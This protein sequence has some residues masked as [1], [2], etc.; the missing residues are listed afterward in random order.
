[1]LDRRGLRLHLATTLGRL[2]EPILFLHQGSPPHTDVNFCGLE[3]WRGLR[4]VAGPVDLFALRLDQS[5]TTSL[6]IAWSRPDSQQ[7]CVLTL[8][9]G[10]LEKS[11]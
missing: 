11:V 6:D 4:L 1:M 3:L 7:L 5:L 9:P 10:V 2:I 8:Q